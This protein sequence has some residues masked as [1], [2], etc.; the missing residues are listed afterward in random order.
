MSQ[1]QNEKFNFTLSPE[2]F[3]LD[4]IY[5]SEQVK[6][7]IPY[8]KSTEKQ[9][10]S[11]LLNARPIYADYIIYK[12]ATPNNGVNVDL[13]FLDNNKFP[14]QTHKFIIINDNKSF[15]GFVFRLVSI[16]FKTEKNEKNN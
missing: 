16:N 13:G 8:Y 2:Q 9:K 7:Q 15:R 1:L 14:I 6:K 3:A 4:S 12:E 10:F 11:F 5:V